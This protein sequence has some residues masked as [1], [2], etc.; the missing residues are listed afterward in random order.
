MTN[1]VYEGVMARPLRIEYAGAIH[2]VTARGNAGMAVFGDDADRRRFLDLFEQVETR[3]KWVCYAYCLWRTIT[4]WWWK[5]P[6]PISPPACA[7]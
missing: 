2:H 6:P 1:L 7:K 5:R 4:I 3:F